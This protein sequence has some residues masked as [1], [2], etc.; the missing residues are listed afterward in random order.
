MSEI[1][2]TEDTL[3]HMPTIVRIAGEY[4]VTIMELLGPGKQEK[5][6][7]AR[8]A[9]CRLL[10]CKELSNAAIGRVIGRDRSTVGSL[11]A[12]K[13]NPTPAYFVRR[14]V[15]ADADA[16]PR[17]LTTKNYKAHCERGSKAL[18]AAI[19]ATGKTHGPMPEQKLIDAMIWSRGANENVH[20]TGWMV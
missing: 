14:E 12:H 18:A 20:C 13:S 2:L 1:R 5:R 7:A 4:G 10:R 6:V 17:D 15:V 9:L 11:L 19:F 8:V 3:N 16:A